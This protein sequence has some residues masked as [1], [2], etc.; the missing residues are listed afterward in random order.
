MS[1]GSVPFHDAR[2][3]QDRFQPLERREQGSIRGQAQYAGTAGSSVQPGWGQ[4]P[5]PNQP[6][7]PGIDGELVEREYAVADREITRKAFERSTFR[8]FKGR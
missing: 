4:Y 8:E 6:A 5:L 7:I 2:D 1:H 3:G